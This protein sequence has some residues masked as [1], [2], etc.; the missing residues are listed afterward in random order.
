MRGGVGG[1]VRA[2][3]GVVISVASLAFVLGGVDLARTAQ[4]LGT[5]A[6]A[7]VVLSV[8]LQASDVFLRAVRW[9]RLVAPIRSVRLARMLA[10]LLVG[11]L[12]NNILP[13]RLGELVRS[14][15]LGDPFAIAQRFVNDARHLAPPPVK[16]MGQSASN[17]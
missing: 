5:A 16:A 11:Y 13:A 12:A 2:V 6:P 3:L 17:P 10:Y 1:T 4:I 7:W 8:G 9:Q 14:H 15:Y